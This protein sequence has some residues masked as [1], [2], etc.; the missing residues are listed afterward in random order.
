[1][2]KPGSKLLLLIIAV[3]I[4]VFS[5]VDSKGQSGLQDFIKKV[6]EN[7]K[8]MHRGINSVYFKGRSRSYFYGKWAAMDMDFFPETEDYLFEGYWI[9]PDSLRI[10]VTAIRKTMADHPAYHN[11]EFSKPDYLTTIQRSFPLPNPFRFNYDV[12]AIGLDVGTRKDKHGKK[13]PIWPVFPFAAGADSLYNYNHINTVSVNGREL[14]RVSVTPKYEEIPGV[15]GTFQI[16]PV[17][18]EIVSSDVVFNKAAKLMQQGNENNMH[19]PATHPLFPMSI[20][21][22]HMIRTVKML[23]YSVYWLPG[24]IEEDFTIRISGGLIKF[25]RNVEF[26]DYEI[27]PETSVAKFDRN[28]KLVY[29]EKP[30]QQN[31]LNKGLERP[32]ELSR[33]EIDSMLNI[34]DI[35]YAQKDVASEIIDTDILGANALKLNLDRKT[36]NF[37]EYARKWSD[38]IDYNRVEGL[39]ADIPLN[40]P[41]VSGRS[42]FVLKGG[43]GFKDDRF[44]G[45]ISG[46]V[47]LNSAKT[48]FFE[49]NIYDT[50]TSTEDKRKFSNAKNTFSSVMYGSDYRDY[51]YKKGGS[52]AL[53]I[54]PASN[55]GIKVSYISQDEDNARVNTNFNIFRNSKDFRLNPEIM[56]GTFRGIRAVMMLRYADIAADFSAEYTD[57]DL[58]ASDFRYSLYKASIL[59]ENKIN[60]CNDL[61]LFLSGGI[62]NGKIPP[63][64]WFDFGGRSLFNYRGIL[65]GVGY[66]DFTGDR[67]FYGTAEYVWSIGDIYQFTR[68]KTIIDTLKKLFKVTLWTG[69][70]WSDLSDENLDYTAGIS[71]PIRTTDDFY[72]EIGIGFSDRLNA[73]R[74]DLIRNSISENRILFSINI[75]R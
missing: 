63:Q 66:K 68:N 49:G 20:E 57:Q 64:E 73:F 23:F 65:R 42:S 6:Q 48:V 34:L 52:A 58:L 56:E 71:T 14:I 60:S 67:V 51:Y 28:E 33:A 13:I 30:E 5:P 2:S 41:N 38:N 7:T 3:S 70:G 16:D 45:E 40:F 1:M 32:F 11:S 74:I 37:M 29:E 39:R 18:K 8:E 36:G 72:S 35:D 21:E 25:N 31:L 50:I 44:K 55:I 19:S 24:V 12:S 10:I 26:T 61:H 69:F 59:Y 53:G 47:F 62:S 54:R 17:L 75:F 46:L 27:N 15:A 9:R 43:Y 4:T 22:E